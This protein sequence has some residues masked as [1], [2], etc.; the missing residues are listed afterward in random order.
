MN[1]YVRGR[2]IVA[3]R[4]FSLLNLDLLVYQ[5]LHSGLSLLKRMRIVMNNTDCVIFFVIEAVRLDSECG[6]PPEELHC[7]YAP[8]G[9][10]TH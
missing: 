5:A 9:L 4:F 7:T 10:C 3:P 2:F 6:H 8:F 1:T